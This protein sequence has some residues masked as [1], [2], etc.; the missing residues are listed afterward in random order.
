MIGAIVGL[1]IESSVRALLLATLVAAC[2]GAL[3]VRSSDLRHRAW[4]AVLAGMLLMPALTRI[5][6]A[7]PVAVPNVPPRLVIEQTM[8]R[9]EGG[10]VPGGIASIATPAPNQ[11]RE[12]TRPTEPSTAPTRRA[13]WS[14]AFDFAQARAFDF[15]QAR[16]AIGL[17]VYGIGLLVMLVRTWAGWRQAARLIA[18]SEPIAPRQR[19][20]I[21]WRS[22]DNVRESPAV[23]V[24]LVVG[25]LRPVIV[26]PVDWRRWTDMD[27]RAVLAHELAHLARRDPLVAA[28]AHANACLFWFHPLAWWLKRHL[29]MLA[30]RACD[31]AGVRGV[32]DRQAYARALIRMAARARRSGGRLQPLTVGIDGH[33]RLTRRI[34]RVLRG[35]M[36]RA[37]RLTT[38]LLAAACSAAIASAA[39]CSIGG[40]EATNRKRIEQF[41]DYFA[42]TEVAVSE[43]DRPL[44]EEVLLRRKAVD[45]SRNWSERLGRFYAA[46]I[47]GH[48]VPVTERGPLREI[49]G[50]DP[51]SDGGF[52]ATVRRKLAESDDPA[53]LVA[54]A[55][56]LRHAPRYPSPQS[57][58][59]IEALARSCLERAVRLQ[60]DFVE[61]RAELVAVASTE[62]TRTG[63]RSERGVAPMELEKAV[64]SLPEPEQFELLPEGAVGAL[65]SARAAARWNDRNLD[66]YARLKTD[67][68][69]KFSEKLLLLAPKFEFHPSHGFAVYRANM[70]LASLAARQGDLDSAVRHLAAASNAPQSEEIAYLRGIASWWLIPD[71]LAAGERVAVAE[72]FERMAERSVVDRQRLLDAAA[73]VR[74]GRSP[75]NLMKGVHR[76]MP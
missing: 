4:T 34:D 57:R 30:E 72:F 21:A 69:R 76:A 1:L 17:C 27:L 37:S 3:R 52:A 20:G 68:S 38:G 32:G 18:A 39:G 41:L 51:R 24:P 10:R 74:S 55:G 59:A 26:L 31:D 45:P 23:S 65:I 33:G 2:L 48:W 46:S 49:T 15:A 8:Q 63:W 9:T 22:G 40:D 35:D 62:R 70:V 73:D 58:E 56:Y 11:P 7:F 61:A 16:A 13:S 14:R 12:R 36:S 29:A 43:A 71:L 25:W 53:M 5:M 64:S 28:L 54:A 42:D 6:P 44:A 67:L 66:D 50:I 47:V 19:A 75:E 60:P